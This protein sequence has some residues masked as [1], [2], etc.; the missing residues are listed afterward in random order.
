MIMISIVLAF[1]Y[2][3]AG[4]QVIVPPYNQIIVEFN[5]SAIDLNGLVASYLV[6][7]SIHDHDRE[8]QQ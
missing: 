5:S 1:V 6:M 3:S 2:G 8:N 4:F 7:T